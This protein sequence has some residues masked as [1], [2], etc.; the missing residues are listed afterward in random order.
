MITLTYS[1]IA[2]LVIPF[3][4]VVYYVTKL[5][6]LSA[7]E[8]Y[9]KL[10]LKE[11]IIDQKSYLVDHRL[12][13]KIKEVEG[14][15]ERGHKLQTTLT[16]ANKALITSITEVNASLSDRKLLLSHSLLTDIERLIHRF[17]LIEFASRIF[18]TKL[19][20]K[21]QAAADKENG[22][23][24]DTLVTIV[25]KLDEFRIRDTSALNG[26]NL[27]AQSYLIVIQDQLKEL[28]RDKEIPSGLDELTQCLDGIDKEITKSMVTLEMA[29]LSIKG[30]QDS[31]VTQ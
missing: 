8:E 13:G 18:I 3:L 22:L 30:K 16:E 20:G 14:L 5:A 12:E 19:H 26:I 29:L 4:V 31:E 2:I 25:E 28:T 9:R 6:K 23:S 21:L 10:K 1:E 7:N 27:D 24:Q 15:M 17:S 11:K